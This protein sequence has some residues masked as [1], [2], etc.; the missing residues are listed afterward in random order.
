MRGAALRAAVLAGSRS[1]RTP[2]APSSGPS[3]CSRRSPT[4]PG[5]SRPRPSRSSS[6]SASARATG[7]STPSRTG[8]T[9]SGSATAASAWAARPRPSRASSRRASMWWAPSGPRSSGWRPRREEDTYLALFRGGEIA[10]AEVVEGSKALHIGGLEVGFSRVAHAHRARQGAPRRMPRR[11]DRRLPRAA[12]PPGVHAADPR[13]APR[14]QERTCT[15]C[16]RRAWATTSRSWPMGCCCVAAPVRDA[17][18]AVVGLGGP[19][20]PHGS[21]A[22]GGGAPHAAVRLRRRPGD[23]CLPTARPQAGLIWNVESQRSPRNRRRLAPSGR[24]RPAGGYVMRRLIVVVLA[25]CSAAAAAMA[26]G[27]SF[28]PGA[29]TAQASR[30]TPTAPC[31]W[32]PSRYHRP[33]QDDLPDPSSGDPVRLPETQSGPRPSASGPRR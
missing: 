21:L 5:R 33:A 30:A 12:A 31:T 26:L 23:R 1:R 20:D 2:S 28:G 14:H 8:A 25:I 29:T 4:L 17:R 11:R 32:T 10:V 18:G 6:G 9:S 7:C 27:A 16:A 22:P 3:T 24:L 13:P 19:L 15:P